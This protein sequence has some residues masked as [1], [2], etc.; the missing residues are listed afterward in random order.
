MGLSL[1]GKVRFITLGCKVNQYETQAMREAMRGAGAASAERGEKEGVDFVVI[2]T[3]T[4]TGDADRDN[5]YWI[6]RARREHPGARIVVTGCMVTR[7]RALLESLPEVDLVLSNQQKSELVSRLLE[8]C[9]A[10]QTQDMRREEKHRYAPLSIS[11][12][13]GN[14][15]AF[16]KIQDG[17]NH[18]CSFCKVVLARGRSRSRALADIVAEVTR[19]RDSGYREIVFAGI[20]LGAYGLDFT[21]HSAGLEE[22]LEACSKIEGIERLRLSSIEPTDVTPS[23]I[24]ALRGIPKC[25]PHLHIPLQSGDDE[26][27]EK[28]NRR[29]GRAFYIDLAGRLKNSLPDFSLTLDVMAGFPGEEETHFQNTLDLLETVKPLKCHV[30]PYSRREGTRAARFRDVEDKILR[31]RVD[32]LIAAGD[33]LGR[34]V[35]LRYEGAR[36]PVL[37]EEVRKDGGL[38]QG[39]TPNYLRVCFEGP[40]AQVGGIADVKLLT[41]QG[42][43]FLGRTV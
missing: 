18:A 40:A 9:A 1:T 19:L 33:R 29:Y 13:E 26:I 35:R 31:E 12:T 17:C 37:V 21:D 11:E 3:C 36:M 38:L 24:E 28:M 27:L 30:F 14:G 39:L 7:D 4:V 42:D 5:R 25:V 34:E 43:L 8:S 20:Q 6:R 32:R 23:L 2:N 15:R 16:V 41:L 10:P 22:V